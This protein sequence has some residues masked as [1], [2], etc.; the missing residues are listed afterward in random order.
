MEYKNEVKEYTENGNIDSA[1][2]CNAIT[3]INIGTATV[4]VNNTIPIAT[5]GTL[6]I[7][8]NKGEIDI[9][10]YFLKFGAGTRQTAVIT[11]I[12]V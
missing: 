6:I 10:Q 4:T 12:Y 1:I 7:T 8:G 5:G 3:F 9:T 2:N 11:K